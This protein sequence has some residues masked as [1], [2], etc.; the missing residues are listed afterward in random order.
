MGINLEETIY[1]FG[2]FLVFFGLLALML[3]DFHEKLKKN[4]S[5]SVYQIVLKNGSLLKRDY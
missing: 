2:F 1:L 3:W 5:G 4:D